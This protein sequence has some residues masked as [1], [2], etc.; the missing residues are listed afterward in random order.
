MNLT[1]SDY[2]NYLLAIESYLLNMYDVQVVYGRGLKDAYYYNDF[3]ITSDDYITINNRRSKENQ[4]YALLHEAGHVQLRSNNYLNTF[5]NAD[6]RR[7]TNGRR[8]DVFRE[9]V[10]AW[11]IGKKIARS[12]QIPINLV[13]YNKQVTSCLMKYAH[14]VVES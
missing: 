1:S 8:I 7:M 13:K 5:P 12:L 6:N 14:W 3:E 9:E 10:M 4:L 11:N 2:E